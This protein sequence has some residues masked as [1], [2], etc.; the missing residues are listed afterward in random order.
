LPSAI[1]KESDFQMESTP[2]ERPVW[3]VVVASILDFFAIFMVGGYLIARATGGLTETGFQ[4]NGL[5]AV[6]LFALVILWFFVLGR[7]FGGTPF[8]RLFG[9]V[10]R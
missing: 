2:A 7:W 4:L 6:A 9:V 1:R 3:K 10:R 8:R 5:P